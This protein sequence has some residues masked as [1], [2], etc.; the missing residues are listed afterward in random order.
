[1]QPLGATDIV[2]ERGE[3]SIARLK[4]LTAGIGSS[5]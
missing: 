2:T 4:E 5:T 1:V 3:E